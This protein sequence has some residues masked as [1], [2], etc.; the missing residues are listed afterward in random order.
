MTVHGDDNHKA[1]KGESGKLP[2]PY[3]PKPRSQRNAFVNKYLQGFV[4]PTDI[5]VEAPIYYESF[6]CTVSAE[7][8]CIPTTFVGDASVPVSLF[9]FIFYLVTKRAH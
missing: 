5:F 6:D 3:F 8:F 7:E 2:I 1:D 9:Y 4:V